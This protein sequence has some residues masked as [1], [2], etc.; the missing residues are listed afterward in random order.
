MLT[1]QEERE[2]KKLIK[3][4]LC[5]IDNDMYLFQVGIPDSGH[6]HYAALSKDEA[7]E[8]IHETRNNVPVADP[9]QPS[10]IITTESN[11]NPGDEHIHDL[12]IFFDYVNHTF[13]VTDI[14]NNEFYNHEAHLIGTGYIQSVSDYMAL[15]SLVGY[16]PDAIIIKDFTYVGPD[17]NVYTTLGGLFKKSYSGVEN[18]GTIIVSEDNTVWERDWDK[19]HTHPEWWQ[20]GGYDHNGVI[21][22][23]K[24][25]TST[26][27]YNDADRINSAYH[28]GT[29]VVLQRRTYLVD[30]GIKLKNTE[31]NGAVI[32]SNRPAIVTSTATV[33]VGST[34]IPVSDASNYR[35]GQSV[36]LVD[37]S[38][39]Y[40]GLGYGEHMYGL[41]GNSTYIT[42]IT[43]NNIT[44]DLPTLESIPSGNNFG[45]VTNQAVISV[46]DGSNGVV[47]NNVTFDGDY[48]NNIITWDW[49]FNNEINTNLN[50][51]IIGGGNKSSFYSCNF[52]NIVGTA[53]TG[54]PMAIINC[55]GDNIGGGILH[56]GTSTVPG[57]DS[58]L[59]YLLVDGLQ[60]SNIGFID[61]NISYHQEAI[62]TFSS[63]VK[64]IS[65]S[66]V[67]ARKV[68]NSIFGFMNAEDDSTFELSNSTFEGYVAD[69]VSDTNN[70][71]L[72]RYSVGFGGVPTDEDLQ[73]VLRISN[74]TFNACGDIILAGQN[75]EQ[76][77]TTGKIVLQSNK[78]NGVRIFG[79]AVSNVDIINNVFT[80][81]AFDNFTTYTY[82]TKNSGYTGTSQIALCHSSHV[83]ITGNYLEGNDTYNQYNEHGIV[84][85]SKQIFRKTSAG[86]N[87][88]I[89]Y[90]SN[91]KITDNIVIKYTFPIGQLPGYEDIF[92]GFNVNHTLWGNGIFINTVISGNQVQIHKDATYNPFR[93]I[94]GIHALPNTTVENNVIIGPENT[95]TS[96]V[97]GIIYYG[98][99][100]AEKS[101][102]PGGVIKGNIV[103]DNGANNIV[104][105]TGSG[106][107]GMMENVMVLNNT[108]LG[109]IYNVNGHSDYNKRYTTV[110]AHLTTP[111]VIP[112]L[113]GWLQ[114]KSQY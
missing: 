66:N 35:V 50:A 8:L 9:S 15:R 52:N 87:T 111:Y 63:F 51:P 54:A 77:E 46:T 62:F 4:S 48:P 60:L 88:K 89:W 106:G 91:V 79:Y 34:V 114:N 20:C 55:G 58:N 90:G 32:K 17:G 105:G 30:I 37:G 67:T 108:T 56:Y 68:A 1:Q 101:N 29:T 14:S 107:D 75:L 27:I 61:P 6:I 76:G 64:N 96:V 53:I 36:L 82:G 19:I 39:P 85:T 13:I 24:Y 43:G 41:L 98:I 12:T 49:R 28:V 40:G 86:A 93:P 65:I 10:V 57:Y 102:L 112:D 25:I 31:G 74:C 38:K 84:V 80:N 59:N 69:W 5:C 113:A 16:T 92:S 42:N 23:N 33:D 22:T 72:F 81:T 103:W 18:G 11:G 110:F 26:G 73:R 100:D 21:Y 78:F 95:P 71:L 83:N 97:R 2:V 44:I 94:W 3:K 45:V 70:H 47:I 7:Q 99:N 104:I 109:A